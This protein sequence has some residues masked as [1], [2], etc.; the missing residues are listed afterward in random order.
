MVFIFQSFI[1][2]C[3]TFLLYM[4]FKKFALPVQP[5]GSLPVNR[6]WLSSLK[7]DVSNIAEKRPF[8]E[9][10]ICETVDMTFHSGK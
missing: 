2:I 7:S 1:C 10:P 9:Y 6:G 5:V 4:V 3:H 8:T